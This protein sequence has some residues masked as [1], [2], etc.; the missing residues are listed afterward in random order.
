MPKR[1]FICIMLIILLLTGCNTF[2]S[3]DTTNSSNSSTEK[4]NIVLQLES[5]HFK[6]YSKE[7][8]KGCLKDLSNELENNYARVTNDLHTSLDEKTN[9]YIYSDLKSYHEAI[10]QPDAPNWA[11]GNAEL[12]DTIDMVNPLKAG[13]GYSHSDFMK[14]IVHEFTHIVTAKINPNINSIPRWLTDGI[15]VYEAKQDDNVNQ[16]I[17]RAKAINKFPKLKDLENPYTFGDDCGYQ[18]SY[19]I[20]DFIIKT[21]GYDKLIALIKSPADFEKILGITEDNFQKKWIS[22]VK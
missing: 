5:S 2:K 7:Q 18:Y 3:K 13:N 17:S 14:V 16:V 15:A 21:Y 6:F 19:S 20:V 12:P 22:Y 10:Y 9:I 4:N 11:V 8:D 1:K